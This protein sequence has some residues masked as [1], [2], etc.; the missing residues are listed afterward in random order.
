MATIACIV[1]LLGPNFL[2]AVTCFVAPV[3]SG[4]VS[5]VERLISD[6]LLPLPHNETDSGPCKAAF[7]FQQP[8]V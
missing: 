6:P 4:G 1:Y 3:L 7:G 5:P 2:Q 8:G